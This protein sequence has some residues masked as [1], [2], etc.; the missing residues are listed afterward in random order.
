[1]NAL[2]DSQLLLAYVE[3]R[4]EAAFAELVRRHIGLVHSAAFRMVGDS[5]LAKDVSQGVFVALAKDA[6]KLTGHPVLVGWLHRTGRNIAAQTVRT[7]VRR[8]NREKEAAAMN[9]SPETDAEWQEIAPHLD[10]ALADLSEP[11]RDAVLLRYFENKPAREMAALLGISAEAA[12]K[13]VSRAVERLRENFAKRG[14]TVGAAGLASIISANAVQTA[15]VGLAVTVS[16]AALADSTSTVLATTQTLAMTIAGKALAA[17]AIVLLAGAGIYHFPR[18]AKSSPGKSPDQP[19]PLM[20][21]KQR[22]AEGDSLVEK[23]ARTRADNPP[24]DRKKELERLK[25]KWMALAAKHEYSYEESTALG[26]ESAKLLLCSK[27]A[28]KLM[29]F[30][31][32]H[33][34]SSNSIAYAVGIILK[35]PEAADARSL[36]VELPDKPGGQREDWSD[37]AGCGCPKEEFEKFYAALKCKRCAQEALFGQNQALIRT[38]PAAA[39][40]S[41]LEAL[42]SNEPSMYSSYG[43]RRLFERDLPAGMDFEALEK[44]LPNRT[45]N[46]A[47]PEDQLLYHPADWLVDGRQ[48]LFEKWA[49]TDAAAAAKAANY[50]LENP[51]R[52]PPALV[53]TITLGLASISHDVRT[54]DPAYVL[55]WVN[56]F[57]EGPYLDQAADAAAGWMGIPYP[58]EAKQLIARISDP[59]MRK[60]CLLRMGKLDEGH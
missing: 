18:G 58:D 7:E 28:V 15:P 56:Q 26:V 3:R 21:Q 6:G 39:I 48:I 38:D 11:D 60:E 35:S 2:S 32:Q 20:T 40:K 42:E 43:L 24:V 13:R 29:E 57:P 34:I 49:K 9:E 12:Q 27:E 19:P 22:P 23:M 33:E 41:T 8:R 45:E 31:E 1:M 25:V 37:D 50:V 16:A 55:E 36:L 17:A 46:P 59:E 10:T 47:V 5:H 54:N 14:I 4:S 52:C 44:L 30:L 53:R 51:N